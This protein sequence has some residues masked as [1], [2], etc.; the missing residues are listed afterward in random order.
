MTRRDP[1]PNV[2]TDAPVHRGDFGAARA[3]P[4]P[5]ISVTIAACRLCISHVSSRS[6][7]LLRRA[8]AAA[9]LS[10]AAVSAVPS[11]AQARATD[12]ALLA[13][14]AQQAPNTRSIAAVTPSHD[15][16]RLAVVTS[17]RAPGEQLSH[18][19]L[20]VTNEDATGVRAIEVVDT[21]GSGTEY[22]SVGRAAWSADDRV[23]AYN[24]GNSAQKYALH[25][26][27]VWFAADGSFELQGLGSLS[28]G[29][30]FTADG[31]YF[32]FSQALGIS[33]PTGTRDGAVDL[34]SRAVLSGARTTYAT[35]PGQPERPAEYAAECARAQ[36]PGWTPAATTGSW[37]ERALS[38]P[39][40]GCRFGANADDP[41][42]TP[43]P[44]PS[45]S[46]APT[47]SAT[48]EPSP[49]PTPSPAPDTAGASDAPATIT[50]PAPGTGLVPI[51]ERTPLGP[52]VRFRSSA[53]GL[54]RAMQRGLRIKLDVAGATSLKAYVLVAR[55]SS[56]GLFAFDGGSTTF[57]IGRLSVQ[58]PPSQT[59]TI[60]V[61]F[62]RDARKV[63][64]RFLKITVTVRL[65]ATDSAGNRTIVE[66]Q[67]ALTDF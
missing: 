63:L 23:L 8:A 24:F 2:V 3:V 48:P 44:E 45:P 31:R 41:A 6:R 14:I 37:M 29:G 57:T 59:Q 43:T 40:P 53:K 55:P 28:T 9:A 1:S 4:A 21:A 36:E 51:A 13:A 17:S 54:T 39:D 65:V 19:N 61:P 22:I 25:A 47:P 16:D 11:L 18:T 34:A 42:A 66:R 62:T 20:W 60:A 46:P 35:L 32:T 52:T 50:R 49:E 30:A 33:G 27:L 12:D 64:P 56:E 5:P 15:G 7:H 10:L 67:V 38:S 26:S 58:R